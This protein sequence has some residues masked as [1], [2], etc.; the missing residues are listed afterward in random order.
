VE[1]TYRSMVAR[2][3]AESKWMRC[4][5]RTKATEPARQALQRKFEREVDPDG[6]L[7]PDELAIR[8]EHARKAYYARLALKSAK[9]RRGRKK[10]NQ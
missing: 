3:G 6:E 9:A 8:A 1:D 10:A 2:L 5:D 4:E 7:P